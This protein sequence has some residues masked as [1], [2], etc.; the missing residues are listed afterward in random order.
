[1][2]RRCD[3]VDQGLRVGVVAVVVWEMEDGF[4]HDCLVK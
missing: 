1:M 3:H 4:C 2:G